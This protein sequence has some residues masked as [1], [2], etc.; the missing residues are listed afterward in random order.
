MI[1]FRS[2]LMSKQN[3]ASN[4]VKEPEGETLSNGK[5]DTFLTDLEQTAATK[6]PIFA[7]FDDDELNMP[8]ETLVSGASFFDWEAN[9][10]VFVGQFKGKK[11]LSG[12]ELKDTALDEIALEF[13]GA[14]RRDYLLGNNYAIADAIEIC[15]N[16][17]TANPWLWIKFLGKQE[18][19]K[20]KFNRYKI[21][22]I[23]D[24]TNPTISTVK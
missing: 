13:F 22:L 23:A 11:S 3:K 24:P 10:P 16:K 12:D 4:D 8:G 7:A 21:K 2:K 18:A 6:K 17:G 1:D 15:Q 14:D 20:G 19:K 9:G 5:E